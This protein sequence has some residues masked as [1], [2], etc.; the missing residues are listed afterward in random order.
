MKHLMYFILS[1][2]FVL[3]ILYIILG[4]SIGVVWA[5]G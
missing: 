5:Y 2:E 4:L 1:D 3:L